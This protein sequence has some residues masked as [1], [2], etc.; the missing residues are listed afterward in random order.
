MLLTSSWLER[1]EGGPEAGSVDQLVRAV[2]AVRTVRERTRM[3]IGDGS[4]VAYRDPFLEAR[5]SGASPG[6]LFGRE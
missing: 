5:P 1:V 6:G 2:V 4:L 3:G